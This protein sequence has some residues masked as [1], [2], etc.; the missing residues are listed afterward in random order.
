MPIYE[1][2]KLSQKDEVTGV[3]SCIQV[4][5]VVPLSTAGRTF[6]LF[7][8]LYIHVVV[9]NGTISQ[10]EVYVILCGHTQILIL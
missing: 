9:Q 10:A 3:I 8:L 7:K 5:K 4:G 6:M 1:G 2:R